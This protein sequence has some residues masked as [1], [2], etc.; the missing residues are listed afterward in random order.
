[1]PLYEH[2]SHPHTPRNVNHVHAEERRASINTRIAVA[3]TNGL[4]TMTC[5][6]IFAILAIMG[7]PGLHAAIPQYIQ[8][9]SQ[10]FIQ[11]TCLSILAVGQRVI[12]R[13]GELQ[14]EE[15]YNNTLKFEHDMNEL[16]HHLDIQDHK[17]LEMEELILSY[18]KKGA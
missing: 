3:I 13:Q 18:L 1:M 16:M 2:Q 12:N 8:W 7:F 15:Q 10:T 4:G 9:I 5:A 6:Y 17:I 11:L 14:A